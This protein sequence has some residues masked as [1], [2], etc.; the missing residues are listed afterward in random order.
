MT[1]IILNIFY[2]VSIVGIFFLAFYSITVY[3]DFKFKTTPRVNVYFENPK[4][5]NEYDIYHIDLVIKNEGEVSVEKIILKFD[6]EDIFFDKEYSDLI[7]RNKLFTEGVNLSPHS[8]FRLQ[9]V[10]HT[11]EFKIHGLGKPYS[12]YGH[13]RNMNDAIMAKLIYNCSKKKYDKNIELTLYHLFYQN[14]GK[15]FLEKINSLEKS[16]DNISKNINNL[17]I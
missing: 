1:E 7:F 14:T 15:T 5:L 4:L 17:K 6:K 8:E 10:I 9:N 11:K 3:R 2:I 16:L 12:G 13:Y